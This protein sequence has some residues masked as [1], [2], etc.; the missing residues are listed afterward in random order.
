[1]GQISLIP[2]PAHMP[3]TKARLLQTW[4]LTSPVL[5]FGNYLLLTLTVLMMDVTVGGVLGIK[6][7][8]GTWL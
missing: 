6:T 4:W 2:G 1:M 7:V 5:E 3:V 8:Q